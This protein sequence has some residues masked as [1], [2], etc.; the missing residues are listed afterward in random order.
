M[1]PLLAVPANVFDEYVIYEYHQ[2]IHEL[3]HACQVSQESVAITQTALGAA[4]AGLEH[5]QHELMGMR[6]TFADSQLALEGIRAQLDASGAQLA[7]SQTQLAASEAR[8]GS[9]QAHLETALEE[10]APFRELG[11]IAISVARRLRRL[12]TRSPRL[13]SIAKRVIRRVHPRARV[14][15]PDA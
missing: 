1:L 10:L 7:A 8:L 12:S 13:A 6:R 3:R 5:A 2:Q 11:P 9:T 4:Q 15:V 14:P